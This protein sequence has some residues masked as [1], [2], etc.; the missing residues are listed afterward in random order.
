RRE[1]NV[2]DGQAI[3]AYDSV[4]LKKPDSSFAYSGVTYSTLRVRIV[5]LLSTE[6]RNQRFSR[7]RAR[8]RAVD[9]MAR[10]LLKKIR[11]KRRVVFFGNGQCGHGARGPCP[12][13]A[14]IRALGLLCPVVLVDE[15]RTS[16]CCCGC[17]IPLRQVGGSRVFRCASQTDENQACS[18]GLIDRDTNGS[19]NRDTKG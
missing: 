15:F 19:V 10:D 7:L 12:R 18:V 13:K 17:G 5:E 4:P 6:R 8:Q 14:L 3:R 11:E 16:K 1:Q 9:G 2:E